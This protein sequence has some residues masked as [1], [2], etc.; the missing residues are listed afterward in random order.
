MVMAGAVGGAL[1]DIDAASMWSGFDASFGRLFSLPYPGREIYGMKL[2]YSHHAFFHSLAGALIVCAILW[3]AGYFLSKIFKKDA[4]GSLPSYFKNTMGIALAFLAGY[5]AHI[6]GDL[7]TPSSVWG[8]I[9]LFWPTTTY[10]GGAGDI[11]WW[12]NYDIFIIAMSCALV[13]TVLMVTL[14]ERARKKC[15]LS[16]AALAILICVVQI[17]TRQ[18]DY[19][20]TGNTAHY[21]AME[22][23]SKQE[24]K[25]ILGPKIYGWM[26][27][28]D[29][30]APIMF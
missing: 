20:Y 12:N 13:N 11:W 4:F 25:R 1:P 28:L 19:A 30:A 24:Q 2:W 27:K 15:V 22:E 14:K 17:K 10:V 18:Y 7:P 21:A 3:T 16:I 8:G 29:R 9:A 23:H 5:A 26:E 6:I